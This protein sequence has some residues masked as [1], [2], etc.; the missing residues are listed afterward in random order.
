MA[1][2]LTPS[3]SPLGADAWAFALA[4]RSVRV[5]VGHRP[6]RHELA[7][8]TATPADVEGSRS[9]RA[10]ASVARHV[11]DAS[12]PPVSPRASYAQATSVPM[13]VPALSGAERPARSRAWPPAPTHQASVCVRTAADPLAGLTLPLAT[14]AR[15]DLLLCGRGL[16][17]RALDALPEVPQPRA[18]GARRRSTLPRLLG[19]LTAKRPIEAVGLLGTPGDGGPRCFEGAQRQQ[20]QSRFATRHVTARRALVRMTP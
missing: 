15:A 13:P 18:D 11:V 4:P 20:M 12:S 2:R 1:L 3:S 5:G 7:G 19:L 16:R 14:A 9:S 17:T 10:R 6:W 8:P